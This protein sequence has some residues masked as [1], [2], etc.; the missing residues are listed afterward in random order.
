M[1]LLSLQYCLHG[2]ILEILDENIVS[3]MFSCLCIPVLYS[4]AHSKKFQKAK[5]KQRAVM[6]I[7]IIEN[8]KN[9]M[10]LEKNIQS[11][12]KG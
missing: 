4:L 3:L 10:Q 7:S 6:K 11:N 1:S 9:S 12:K 8:S 2:N 5:L